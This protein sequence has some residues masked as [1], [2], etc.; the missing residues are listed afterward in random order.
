MEKQASPA[1]AD[2]ALTPVLPKVMPRGHA[3]AKEEKAKCARR[4]LQSLC[5]KDGSSSCLLHRKIGFS[6]AT[7]HAADAWS[8]PLPNTNGLQN[9]CPIFPIRTNG[10]HRTAANRGN[11]TLPAKS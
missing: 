10:A 2:A 1:S 6:T 11:G 4:K 3:H 7:N 9:I 5:G 8:A